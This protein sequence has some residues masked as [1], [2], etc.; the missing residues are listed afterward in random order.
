[1]TCEFHLR[2]DEDR[3]ARD[4]PK[5]TDGEPSPE[6]ESDEPAPCVPEELILPER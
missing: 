1:M 4:E 2:C 5:G 6:L 3:F